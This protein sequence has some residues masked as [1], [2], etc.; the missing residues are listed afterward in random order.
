MDVDSTHARPHTTG[1]GA[2]AAALGF[3][4]ASVSY[5]PFRAP[6]ERLRKDL[7]ML[8]SMCVD[9]DGGGW[10]AEAFPWMLQLATE[11]LVR[12]SNMLGYFFARLVRKSV[13]DLE[14]AVFDG[15]PD[16]Q[17]DISCATAVDHAEDTKTA[18][19][20][21]TDRRFNRVELREG[22]LR[23]LCHVAQLPGRHMDLVLFCQHVWPALIAYV[24]SAT[25][26]SS[27]ATL[28]RGIFDA[29][30][31]PELKW[32]L[33][34][35]EA[36]KGVQMALSLCID[37]DVSMP[38]LAIESLWRLLKTIFSKSRAASRTTANAPA[39]QNPNARVRRNVGSSVSV[40]LSYV[41][42]AQEFTE[43][44]FSALRALAGTGDASD[45]NGTLAVGGGVG[46]PPTTRDERQLL[47]KL[48][49]N[50]REIEAQRLLQVCKPGSLKYALDD[51]SDRTRVSATLLLWHQ[52][53]LLSQQQD[54]KRSE[55]RQRFL[56]LVDVM[57]RL[58][59]LRRPSAPQTAGSVGEF[60]CLHTNDKRVH[61]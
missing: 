19:V 8:K 43:K 42:A 18:E 15:L 29:L 1:V 61:E 17:Q 32:P 22:M 44:H 55:F 14:A 50:G 25:T 20:L 47:R 39:A 41:V 51:P 38:S 28:L 34:G 3:C 27:Q 21:E 26:K 12:G 56:D 24:R 58:Q 5:Y 40:L 59:D 54:M 16:G 60:S 2:T 49:L 10:G 57:L 7:G 11:L 48:I 53:C 33:D 13:V 46:A 9:A 35:Q 31:S 4:L 37:D 36:V 23:V 45:G 30:C 6:Y 52:L